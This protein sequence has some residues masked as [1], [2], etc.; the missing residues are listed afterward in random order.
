MKGSP[1]SATSSRV[2]TLAEYRQYQ[3]D[4]G[5]P[6]VRV[7]D[8][9]AGLCAPSP[10]RDRGANAQS[11]ATRA[12]RHRARNVESIDRRPDCVQGKW[13]LR[14]WW[15]GFCIYQ[16]GATAAKCRLD[17][18]IQTPTRRRDRGIYAPCPS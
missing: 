2:L 1:Y 9:T 4:G 5:A 6:V 17:C 15:R 14:T 7:I 11:T 16:T 18:H 8:S 12:S 13:R 3:P 10:L